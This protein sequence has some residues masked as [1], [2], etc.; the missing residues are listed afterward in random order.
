MFSILFYSAL[1]NKQRPLETH[2]HT[3]TYLPC[4]SIPLLY[5]VTGK[6]RYLEL[7]MLGRHFSARYYSE[8]N[9]WL[10]ATC[11]ISSSAS[12]LPT[13]VCA[14]HTLQRFWHRHLTDGPTYSSTYLQNLYSKLSEG[15]WGGGSVQWGVWEVFHSQKNIYH[16]GAAVTKQMSGG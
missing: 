11:S 14:S 12:S 3:Q 2:M 5:V 8:Y 6:E 7:G 1:W 13:S 10:P 16:A 4:H 9:V 15:V